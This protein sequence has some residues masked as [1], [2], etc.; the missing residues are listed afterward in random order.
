MYGEKKENNGPI[1]LGNI[2][3][4]IGRLT[5]RLTGRLSGRLTWRLTEISKYKR[6][7]VFS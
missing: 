6:K 7:D 2:F 5:G 3:K 4:Q 1:H